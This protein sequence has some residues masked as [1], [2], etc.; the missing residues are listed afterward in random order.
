MVM[1]R[2][3][4]I[5]VMH[6]WQGLAHHT[7]EVQRYKAQERRDKEGVCHSSSLSPSPATSETV[8]LKLNHFFTDQENSILVP[9]PI[10]PR[11]FL[12]RMA[13]LCGHETT[14]KSTPRFY[15]IFPP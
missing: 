5:D 1:V 9:T 12:L 4:F 15:V 10:D 8:W 13:P 2:I 6:F 11:Q 14:I 3:S 7:H